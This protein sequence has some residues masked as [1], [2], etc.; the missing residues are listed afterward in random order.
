MKH[1][2]SIHSIAI[3]DSS[4]FQLIPTDVIAH[5]VLK[6]ILMCW[7]IYMLVLQYIQHYYHDHSYNSTYYNVQAS[8][9]CINKMSNQTEYNI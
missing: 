7:H 6:C 4:N 8:A 3:L 5:L 9:P 1:V 2:L